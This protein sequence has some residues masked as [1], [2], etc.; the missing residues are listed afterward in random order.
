M[1]HRIK[2]L[3]NRTGWQYSATSNGTFLHSRRSVKNQHFWRI[4]VFLKQKDTL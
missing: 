3:A 4:Q 1:R 2:A